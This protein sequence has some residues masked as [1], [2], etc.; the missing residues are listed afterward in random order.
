MLLWLLNAFI[1]ELQAELRLGTEKILSSLKKTDTEEEN[2]KTE[3]ERR[4]EEERSRAEVEEVLYD[5]VDDIPYKVEEGSRIALE[6]KL[7]E[8]QAVNKKLLSELQESIKVKEAEEARRAEVEA[9]LGLV[10]MST[11]TEIA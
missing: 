3:E 8:C 4:I 11:E 1:E 6:R 2:R 5:L 9:M 7:E 10:Q